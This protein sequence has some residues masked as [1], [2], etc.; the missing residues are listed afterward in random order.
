[1]AIYNDYETLL[2]RYSIMTESPA[3]D[4]AAALKHCTQNTTPE[5]A[6]R[7]RN[8]ILQ[9]A[10]L[11]NAAAQTQH[12]DFETLSK[13]I[14][15]GLGVYPCI[16][17][18]G[19][20]SPICKIKDTNDAIIEKNRITDKDR[21]KNFIEGGG[22]CYTADGKKWNNQRQIEMFAIYPNQ[23]N[24][25]CIDIDAKTK[26]DGTKHGTGTNG[27]NE[28]LNIIQH[29]D[30]T[31]TQKKMFENFPFNFPCYVSTPSGGI[32]LYFKITSLPAHWQQYG[33]VIIYNGLNTNIE[34]KYN[35]QIT[36]AGSIKN[37]KRYELH[38][39]F[40]NIP[41]IP[42]DLLNTCCKPRE[43]IEPVKRP[44][45]KYEYKQD[46]TPTP[47]FCIDRGKA[48]AGYNGGRHNLFCSVIGCFAGFYK[49]TNNESLNADTCRRYILQDSDF[50]SWKDN[51][52]ESQIN[53]IIKDFY[54]V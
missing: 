17:E 21:L 40:E 33:N 9:P 20:P 43:I 48:L 2:E 25:F 32:H 15:A 29:A 47:E 46:K 23:Y 11:P 22:H 41:F 31:E 12:A 42:T 3:A 19:N 37:G 16:Y 14:D 36:I 13:Y 8:E 10:G 24:L 38:G 1:M 35:K 27:I 5:L 49:T 45:K 52:K 7:L 53:Q 26:Q 4:H 39:N 51:D 34:C 30:L 50:L 18:N 28:F 54:G 44:Y 6:A